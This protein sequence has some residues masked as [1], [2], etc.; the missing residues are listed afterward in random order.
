MSLYYNLKKYN[1]N[2][3]L[4]GIEEWWRTPLILAI[5]EAEAGGFL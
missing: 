1:I 3:K 4:K 2:N 5:W